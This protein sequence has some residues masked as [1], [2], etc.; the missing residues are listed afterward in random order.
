MTVL[1]IFFSILVLRVTA[2]IYAQDDQSG[3]ISIDCGSASNYTQDDTRIYY[4]SD[5]AFIEGG[6]RH[7]LSNNYSTRVYNTIRSFPKNEWNC[8]TLRPKKGKNN[9][10]LIRAIFFY[11][12]SRGQTPQF[13][14]Y[15]GTDYWVTVNITDPS[16]YVA[17]EMIHLTSSDYIN[18]CL[19]NTDEGDPFITALELRL[20]ENT[21]Y[22][23][24]SPSTLILEQRTNFA[25]AM[26]SIKSTYG[27][28]TTLNWQGDPCVP[29]PWVG[30][31][32]SYN[33]QGEAK[34]ISL[35]VFHFTTTTE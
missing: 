3:F 10:Y 16:T 34:I 21:M 12:K 25:A 5:D 33:A 8:Y 35:Y 28:L 2:M 9:R 29:Q 13:D 26:W 4:V 23:E 17:Y 14:L 31:I 7:D 32:C 24:Q 18:V 15:F 6:D 27:G 11:G 20:L 30:L 1:R 22:D 19:V